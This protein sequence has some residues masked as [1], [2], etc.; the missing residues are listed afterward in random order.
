M[1]NFVEKTK[2]QVDI[3]LACSDFLKDPV[4]KKFKKSELFSANVGETYLEFDE[5]KKGNIYLGLGSK[6]L[7]AEDLR[8]AGFKLVKKLQELKIN[9]V[10]LELLAIKEVVGKDYINLLPFVEGIYHGMYKFDKYLSK[11]DE[12]ELTVGLS[13][14]SLKLEQELKELDAVMESVFITRDLVNTPAIDLYPEK[15]A[16]FIKDQLKDLPVEV[17]ILDE[18]QMLEHKM[19]AALAVGMGSDRKPRFVV[20][21]YQPNKESD[22]FLT[23]V[24]KGI[25][26]DSGGYAIK[27]ASGMVDMKTDMAG[28]ASVFASIR[29][30]AKNN[31]Q[32]NVCGVMA[33]CE[34]LVSGSSYKNG[35]VISTMKGITIEVNNTDAEGR[36]TMADSVYYAATKVNSKFIV[37]MS[38][39]TGACIVALGTDVTGS[40]TNNDRLW[41]KV[42]EAG[43][44][45]G[46]LIWKF[47]VTQKAKNANKGTFGDLNNAP[48]YAGSIT[49]GLFVQ[50][51]AEDKP[52]VHLD[53]AGTSYNPPYLYYANGATGVGVRT[54]YNL[55]KDYK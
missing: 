48:R 52:F 29:A 20:L 27:P 6:N 16:N 10:N 46:E 26:Y 12:Y 7:E 30:L 22:E 15:Y 35:D 19:H 50:E 55:V 17:T 53:I 18:K 34:N 1:L 33:L 31:I 11:K 2:K 43:L 8:L 40:I 54:I 13:K 44:K 42:H 23:F 9:H 5:N 32:Q 37:E 28:S 21:K 47:P 49:A 3:L 38:T 39:L 4:L 24:G 25:C 45:A 36:V 14:L 41:N 51:F